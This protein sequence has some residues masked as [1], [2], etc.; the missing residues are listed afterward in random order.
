V[1]PAEDMT[2]L[3]S[4]E[5]NDVLQYEF[6][7]NHVKDNGQRPKYTITNT[8]SSYREIPFRFGLDLDQSVWVAATVRKGNATIPKSITT[9]RTTYR[10]MAQHFGSVIVA[11]TTGEEISAGTAAQWFESNA[12]PVKAQTGAKLEAKLID[13]GPTGKVLVRCVSEVTT[14]KEKGYTYTL[15]IEN[16]ST[17][18][19][20]FKWAG[21]KGK[22]E[23]K[24]SFTQSESATTLTNEQSGLAT[25]DFGNK[26]EFGIRANFWQRP[27]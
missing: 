19:V 9:V 1:T 4:R 6:S 23:P 12:A 14:D 27:K 11:K 3:A 16:L 15:T 8:I 5:N 22:I 24:K 20:S 25:L 21:L 7:S 17:E 26:R 18:A 13:G 2:L 10:P